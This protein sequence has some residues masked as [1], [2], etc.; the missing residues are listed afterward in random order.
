MSKNYLLAVATLMGTIIGVGL[1]AIPWAINQAGVISLFVYMAGLAVIQYWLHL[2]FAEAVL[3]TKEK[4]RVP[5]LMEKYGSKKGKIA[6][7]I[8]EVISSYGSILAYIIV[9]G[10]F[11]HQL[12][13]PYWGGSVFLYSTALFL[14]VELI[15]FFDIKMIAG[16]EFFL[17]ALLV[18]AI[19][20]ITWRGF[21]Q[22]SLDNYQLV[23]WQNIFLPYGPIFFAISGSSAIP[24]VCRLLDREK[25]KIR[26]AIAWGTFLPA[27]LMLIFVLVVLGI[28]GERTS[29]DTLAGLGMVLNDGVITFSLIFG[30]LAIISSYIVIAQSL[31]EVFE[32][33]FKLTNK[34]SWLLAGFVPYLL[35]ALGWTNLTKVISF[36]G[37]FTGGLSGIILIWLMFKIKARPELVSSVKNK[38]SMPLALFLSGLFILGMI[39]EVWSMINK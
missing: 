29:H 1:F 35:Y 26:S 23:N 13:S 4:H 36:T 31:E 11:L 20:L 17:T 27:I 25:H 3:S 14:L 8:A 12:F 32:W 5:G 33:D 21:G 15:T 39:Y 38:L 7:F 9:G 37:A 2:L 30:L 24:E 22:I 34:L 16:A 28:T 18:A 6:A 19:G 10:L